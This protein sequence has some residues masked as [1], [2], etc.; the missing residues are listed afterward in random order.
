[1]KNQLIHIDL[2]ARRRSLGSSSS[3]LNL[4][5]TQQSAHKRRN[6]HSMGNSDYCVNTGK[7]DRL[8]PLIIR[9]ESSNQSARLGCVDTIL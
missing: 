4:R 6:L 7:P 8:I 1:M 2:I 3:G 5:A 9:V